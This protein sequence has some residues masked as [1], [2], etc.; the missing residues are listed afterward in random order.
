MVNNHVDHPAW[1]GFAQRVLQWTPNPRNG[2]KSDQAH[3]PIHPLKLATNLNGNE[4]RVYELICRHFLACV[5]KDATGSETT[6]DVI[7]ADEKFHATGLCIHER[8]Y[9]DVYIY[10]KWNSKEIHKYQMGTEF[11]PTELT[12]LEGSTS[13]PS[14]LTEADLIALMDKH[15]IG[16]D[17]THAEHINTVKTRG[18]FCSLFVGRYSGQLKFTTRNITNSGYIGEIDGGYLVPGT[19]G[20]GLVE[21][22]DTVELPL[23]YPELRAELERD[24][25]LVCSGQKDPK[26]VLNEQIQKYKD[27][28][29]VITE[30]IEA[31]DAKLASR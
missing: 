12:M 13:P 7:V 31:I 15:G 25:K 18:T 21:G 3:P 28:Y 6:V 20:M 27:V 26:H 11:Q 2:K 22:Y 9:L 19:L 16:T 17:A 5:S 30:K 1:G 29:K 4:Q 24:L 8:N 14:L 23:A 10:E